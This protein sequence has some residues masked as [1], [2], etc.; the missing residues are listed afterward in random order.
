MIFFIRERGK[1]L[2]ESEWR[3]RMEIWKQRTCDG[4]QNF[5]TEYE[6]FLYNIEKLKILNFKFFNG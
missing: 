5:K 6:S 1:I 3:Q 2:R 4:K